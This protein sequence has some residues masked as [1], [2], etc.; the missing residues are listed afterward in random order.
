MKLGVRPTWIADLAKRCACEQ[1][2]FALL[3]IFAISGRLR[4]PGVLAATV[5]Q[6]TRTE[7]S[8][9]NYE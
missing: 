8:V 9:V 5:D 2:S 7:T 1:L 6:S 4:L 3:T